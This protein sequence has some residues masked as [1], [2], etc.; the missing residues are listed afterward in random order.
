MAIFSRVA[1]NTSCLVTLYRICLVFGGD[2]RRK[3]GRQR[4]EMCPPFLFWSSVWHFI[5]WIKV[6]HLTSDVC[7]ISRNTAWGG[8][9]L[10][11]TSGQWPHSETEALTA[12][13]AAPQKKW[14]QTVYQA[15]CA[16][17]SMHYLTHHHSQPMSRYYPCS[18]I[19]K[20][21]LTM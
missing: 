18:H 19:R 3:K 14:H 13:A 9:Q 2:G 11:L 7:D 10:S 1:V 15:P 12:P 6:Y 5:I 8:S 4:K 20:L 16:A 17:S 21:K